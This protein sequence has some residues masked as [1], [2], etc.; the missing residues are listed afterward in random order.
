MSN[1]HPV[2]SWKPGQSGNP[3]GKSYIR[4]LSWKEIIKQVGEEATPEE[5]NQWGATYK[6]AAVRRTF[7]EIIKGS[8]KYL[9]EL[10][11]YSEPNSTEINIQLTDWREFAKSN[12]PVEILAE[13]YREIIKLGKPIDGEFRLVEEHTAGRPSD[14]LGGAELAQG[15]A[16]GPTTLEPD[17]EAEAP[18]GDT[19]IRDLVRR[20][21]GRIQKLL[22]DRLGEE[23]PQA[24]P[25]LKD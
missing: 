5:L 13:R 20:S 14:D 3:R 6:E 17:I 16:S 19:G 18:S 12:I 8:I 22:A 11:K 24:F 1:S 15:T 23:L 10:M 4:G 9:P 7:T 21:E 25:T 2:E